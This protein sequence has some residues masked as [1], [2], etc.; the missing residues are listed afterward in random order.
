MVFSRC[1]RTSRSRTWYNV[2]STDPRL[3]KT[4][5]NVSGF[6]TILFSPYLSSIS[7]S[8]FSRREA[9]QPAPV[10]AVEKSK[11]LVLRI[12]FR[13]TLLYCVLMIFVVLCEQHCQHRIHQTCQARGD[14]EMASP[15][16][17]RTHGL[18]VFTSSVTFFTVASSTMSVLLRRMTLANSI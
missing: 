18:R 15:G 14:S 11:R 13:S 8:V 17:R 7:M 3:C 10:A 5:S 9:S 6:G 2:V 4:H 1:R 16:T 12:S